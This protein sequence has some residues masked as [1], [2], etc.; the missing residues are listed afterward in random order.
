MSDMDYQRQAQ[1]ATAN[2]RHATAGR[3][4]GAPEAVEMRM[5]GVARHGD[6]SLRRQ[7]AAAVRTGGIEWV[8]ASDLLAR[9]GG[10]VADRAA[11]AHDQAAHQMRCGMAQPG[12]DTNRRGRGGGGL[13]PVTA[14]GSAPPAPPAPSRAAAS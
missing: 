5:S 2:G 13:P 8:R 3:P 14:F 6:P 7:P 10:R 4:A 12:R 1:A 9:V 11:A